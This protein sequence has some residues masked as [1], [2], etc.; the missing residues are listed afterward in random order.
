VQ[1]QKGNI[2]SSDR[3][4]LWNDNRT[5]V[6]CQELTERMRDLLKEWRKNRAARKELDCKTPE[7]VV[8]E[9]SDNELHIVDIAPAAQGPPGLQD[10]QNL[11][12]ITITNDKSRLSKKASLRRLSGTRVRPFLSNA[13]F[14]L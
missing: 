2:D 8:P 12:R 6:L 11:N 4:V 3:Q 9:L 13:S 5:K 14:L 10:R 1:K 7:E